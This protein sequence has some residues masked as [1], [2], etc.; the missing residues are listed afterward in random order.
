MV[1]SGAYLKT[2]F[3]CV[4]TGSFSSIVLSLTNFPSWALKI[5]SA[6]RGSLQ[7]PVFDSDN[8][9]PEVLCCVRT[10]YFFFFCSFAFCLRKILSRDK[11]TRR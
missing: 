10:I 6:A 11:K 9:S 8:E 1:K 2:V 3:Q 4:G 7:M 5:L